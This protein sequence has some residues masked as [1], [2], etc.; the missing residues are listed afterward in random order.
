MKE[1]I[2]LLNESLVKEKQL[3]SRVVFFVFADILINFFGERLL[4]FLSTK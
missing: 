3:R 2:G 4:T 1:K